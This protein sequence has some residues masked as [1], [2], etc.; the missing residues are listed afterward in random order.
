M[1]ADLTVRL[2]GLLLRLP[3]LTTKQI[4]TSLHVGYFTAYRM[5]PSVATLERVPGYK[6]K[7]RWRLHPEFGLASDAPALPVV[8]AQCDG[9]PRHASAWTTDGMGR[10]IENGRPM[11]RRIAPEGAIRS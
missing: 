6:M 1:S 3:E 5:L 11:A 8:H 7:Y 9:A 2:V 4:A 10:L